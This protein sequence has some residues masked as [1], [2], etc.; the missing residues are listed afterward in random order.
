MGSCCGGRLAFRCPGCVSA[1]C[2][3]R[4]GHG[5]RNGDGIDRGETGALEIAVRRLGRC[6]L[7]EIEA[8]ADELGSVLDDLGNGMETDVTPLD[9]GL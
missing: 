1:G 9:I 7:A 3:R 5:G 2:H 8:Y 4:A 6:R